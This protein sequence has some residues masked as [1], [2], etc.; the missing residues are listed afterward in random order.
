MQRFSDEGLADIVTP[1]GS[2]DRWTMKSSVPFC[3]ATI[4][5]RRGV[6]DALGGY[7]VAP[8][9]RRAEDLDLWFRFFHAG[10]EGKNLAEPL[11]LVR[12]D[13]NA[14]QRRT[15]RSRFSSTY[16]TTIAG[17]KLLGYPALAYA[18]PTFALAK[19]LV[20]HSMVR[21]Y[22]RWQRHR[23]NSPKHRVDRLRTMPV[24][25]LT[26]TVATGLAWLAN[27]P[28]MGNGPR[29]RIPQIAILAG[30]AL[31][32]VAA[33]RWRVGTDYWTYEELYADYVRSNVIDVGLLGE[34]GLPALAKVSQLI[35][36]DSATML[37]LAA[38]MTVGL[39]VATLWRTS[40][41]F[42]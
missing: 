10:L 12:E 37:A 9:T 38:L 4:M 6:F 39:F 1:V 27:A 17:Y 25:V 40:P 36:D 32:L 28:P 20:P 24:Y 18:R 22:R 21:A 31:A 41:S 29:G 3:H 42:H 35:H 14:I 2:P 11:Y 16:L 15:A 13:P 19:G 5:A 30:A 23:L 7:L 8:R 26:L 34:P 33:L